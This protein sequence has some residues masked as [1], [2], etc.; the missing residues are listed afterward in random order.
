MLVNV[1]EGSRT[2]GGHEAHMFLLGA[3]GYRKGNLHE[4]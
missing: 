2:M 4:G 3:K 1:I